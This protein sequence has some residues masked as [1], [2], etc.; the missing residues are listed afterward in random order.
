MTLNA[1]SFKK[2]IASEFGDAE[3]SKA[4]WALIKSAA[5]F[6]GSVFFMRNLGDLMAV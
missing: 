2:W 1:E 6:A 4:N 3:K 5:M